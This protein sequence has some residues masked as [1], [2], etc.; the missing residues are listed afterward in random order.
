MNYEKGKRYKVVK[1]G[2]S[3]WGMKPV[4]PYVQRGWRKDLA[5]GEILT[6]A[7]SSMEVP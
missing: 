7:G 1:E 6:C 4:S 2:S 5:V 3:L